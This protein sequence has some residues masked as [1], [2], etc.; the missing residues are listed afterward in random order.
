MADSVVLGSGPAHKIPE[1][2]RVLQFE[3]PDE[4]SAIG[5][6]ADGYS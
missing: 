2:V 3:Y 4:R 1:Q 6:A 5:G